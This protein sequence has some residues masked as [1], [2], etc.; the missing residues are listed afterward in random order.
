MGRLQS[1]PP[2]ETV[3]EALLAAQQSPELNYRG[4]QEIIDTFNL[5]GDPALLIARPGDG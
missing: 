3:G 2:V 1:L 4:G 5:L